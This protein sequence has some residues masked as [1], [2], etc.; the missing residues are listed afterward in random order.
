[1]L[2][3]KY[4][5]FVWFVYT[6]LNW[7]L[8]NIKLNEKMDIP[9]DLIKT[10]IEVW[11]FY[12]FYHSLKAY[13]DKSPLLFTRSILFFALSLAV[14]I[15]LN[16]QLANF[17]M[18]RGGID[19]RTMTAFVVDTL[20]FYNNYMLLSLG[21]FFAER[22]VLREQSLRKF[23]KEQAIEAQKQLELENTN[24]RLS[25]EKVVLQKGML[26]SENEFLRAQINPHFLFN[27]LN[28]LYAASLGTQP[29]V[30]DGILTL[31]QIMRYSLNQYNENEG[32]AS[33]EQEIDHIQNV[34]KLNQIRFEN[35]LQCSFQV[36]G[37]TKNKF[38]I[39]MVF[40]TLVENVFKH[41][42][43]IRSNKPATIH[44]EVDEAEQKIR[45]STKNLIKTGQTLPS[46]GIG[47]SNSIRRLETVYQ[48][49]FNYQQKAVRNMY[50]VH[51]D[52]P[53]IEKPAEITETLKPQKIENDE[54]LRN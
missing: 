29:I 33:L 37:D 54:L 22:F 14:T 13:N 27:S 24:I 15:I 53:Y 49:N 26:K 5:L 50:I 43:L 23:E 47:T 12:S 45:F 6:V 34:I 9:S 31:A 4:H 48:T 18:Y 21:F 36:V 42:N 44:C 32:L 7:S 25:Q 3:F 39:P 8:N 10:M 17:D 28:T 19:H 40:V 20:F 41:G 11:I 30:A 52:I 35:R 51:V 2:R 1:M 16:R 38:I 46:N